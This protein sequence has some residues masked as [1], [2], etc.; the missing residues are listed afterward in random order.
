MDDKEREKILEGKDIN[1]IADAC[2]RYPSVGMSC[3]ID[4]K[5]GEEV[6]MTVVLEREEELNNYSV[7]S[8]FFPG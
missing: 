2:N 8:S 7:V 4:Q 3:K 5:E 6:E 1:K